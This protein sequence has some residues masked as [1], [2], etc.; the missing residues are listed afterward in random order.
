MRTTHQPDPSA[1]ASEVVVRYR[2]GVSATSA[3]A[4]RRESRASVRRN[5]RF[6]SAQV[7]SV[8]AGSTARSLAD[9]LRADPRVEF[10]FPNVG[11]RRLANT[12]PDLIGRLW[13]VNNSGQPIPYWNPAIPGYDFDNPTPGAVD[14]DVDAPQA[15]VRTKGTRNVIVAVT[16]S[17]V[18]I[19]HP[20]LAPAIYTNPHEIPGNGVDDDGND[21]VD[22]IHGWDF[23]GGG[24]AGLGDNTVFDDPID[25]AH[26]THIAGTIAAADDGHGTIGVAPGVTIMP[27]KFLGKDDNSD[28]CSDDFAGAFNSLFYSVIQG[29]RVINA[30]WGVDL[31]SSLDAAAIADFN[32]LVAGLGTDWGAVVVAAAGNDGVNLD[33]SPVRTY[34]AALTAP[35]VLAVA[36]ADSRGILMPESNRGRAVV[37]I[38]A[39]GVSILSTIPDDNVNGYGDDYAWADGTSMAA[40]HASG[41][42]ALLL[43]AYPALSAAQAVARLK[44][45]AKRSAAMS[46]LATTTSAGG[47]VSAARALTPGTRLGIAVTASAANYRQIITVVGGISDVVTARPLVNAPLQLYY[48]YRGTAAWVYGATYRTDARGIARAPRV[49]VGTADWQW[50]YVGTAAQPSVNSVLTAVTVRSTVSLALS[51]TTARPNNVVYLRGRVAPPAPGKRVYAQRLVSGVWRAL[52]SAPMSPTGA[53]SFALKVTAR[54]TWTVRMVRQADALRAAGASVARG[55]KVV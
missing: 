21:L 30:S 39:P 16:D 2:K 26:G 9:S 27:V 38:A 37:D 49:M 55:I 51:R 28:G 18:D 13:G 41:A 19:N 44:A 48:R 14:V 40:P 34:P 12:A 32:Q 33:T 53:Y 7:V 35:N 22:D 42:A 15:W 52:G 20:D 25:D 10:A 47:I 50:R 24:A 46:S 4:L 43:S 8:P 45:T 31:D 1:R 29:A 54:G 6:A 5:L 36:A 23:C 11:V 17:G 3:A